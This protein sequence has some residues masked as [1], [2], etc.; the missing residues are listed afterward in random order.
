MEDMAYY[1]DNVVVMNDGKIY[2]TGTVDEIFSDAESL[3]S[4]GLDVPVISKIAASLKKQ[5]ISLQGKLYT[6]DGVKEAIK[7]YIGGER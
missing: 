5:G 4:I 3:I 1:C 6:V 7:K 2:K